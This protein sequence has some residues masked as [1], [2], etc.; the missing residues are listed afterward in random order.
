MLRLNSLTPP[1]A[2]LRV[3]FFFFYLLS[4][5]LLS[6]SRGSPWYE[7]FPSFFCHLLE[8]VLH[9]R[10]VQELGQVSGCIHSGC[11]EHSHSHKMYSD[12]TQDSGSLPARGSVV[13][14]TRKIARLPTYSELETEALR[15]S[16]TLLDVS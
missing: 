3:A 4:L 1:P 16:L 7:C 11:C 2:L 12:T 8:V 14:V 15:F 6:S 5:L 10:V 13:H 9:G